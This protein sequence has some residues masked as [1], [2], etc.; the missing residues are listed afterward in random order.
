MRKT[1]KYSVKQIVSAISK[2]G[3]I[4]STIAKRLGCN[5]ETASKLIKFSDET[6]EAYRCEREAI[7]DMCETTLLTSINS[8][9][10]QSSKWLLSTLGRDRGF[11]EKLEVSGKILTDTMTPAERRAR[12][13]ELEEKLRNDAME[14][15]GSA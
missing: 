9:D 8:G 13:K 6:Q 1:C 3:G 10:V 2:S 11:G 7:L 5:W 14:N 12:I 4:K 15:E